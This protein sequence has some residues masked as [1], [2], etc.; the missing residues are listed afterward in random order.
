MLVYQRVCPK[1]IQLGN[2]LGGVDASASHWTSWLGSL[3]FRLATVALWGKFPAPISIGHIN[4]AC[5]FMTEAC[6]HQIVW[7]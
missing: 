5:F 4:I 1:D 3:L 2:M 6:D 7:V